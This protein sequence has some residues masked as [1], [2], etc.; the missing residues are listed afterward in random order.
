MKIKEGFLL[1]EVAGTHVI[2]PVGNVSFNS[3]ITLNGTGLFICEKLMK[4]A[5]ENELLR[6]F[7]QEYE[8]SEEK[9][10]ADIKK[11]LE[12]LKKAGL[13]EDDNQ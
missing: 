11:F 10:A 1:K 13:L 3:M 5:D 8:V 6:D 7:L 4:G 9:A 2:V 12:S